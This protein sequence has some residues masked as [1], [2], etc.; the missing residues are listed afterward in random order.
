MKE[1]TDKRDYLTLAASFH[2]INI[3]W[4]NGVYPDTVVEKAYPLVR[5][6]HLPQ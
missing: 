1:R 6:L 5:M 4:R 3:D 2:G